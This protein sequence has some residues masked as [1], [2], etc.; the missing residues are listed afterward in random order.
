MSG[1]IN[2]DAGFRT[3]LQQH[4]EASERGDIEAEHKIYAANAIL[5]YPQSG[6]RFSGRSTIQAQRGAHPGA[7]RS[8]SRFRSATGIVAAV[9]ESSST[10]DSQRV[11]ITRSNAP[12]AWLLCSATLMLLVIVVRWQLSRHPFPG[13]AWAAQVGASPKPWL[14]FAITRAYQQVGR[15]IVAIG[16]VLVMLAWLRRTSG[17]RAAQGLLIA[18]LASV[19][20]GLIKT[21]C[22]PTSLWLELHHVG[23]NFPSGVVTFVTAAGGYL[24]L[25][26]RQQGRRITP[27]V[28]IVIIVGAG[29]ARVLGGQHVVS[30]VLGGYMLGMAWLIPAY[31]YRVRPGYRAQEEAA[32]SIAGLQAPA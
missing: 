20:C 22:G 32:W 7:P 15:P 26:A 3:R 23:S 28:L 30:D 13:D 4:W 9:L 11:R 5:D 12:R 6:E 10:P 24:A 17:R 2:R 1:E 8:L 18:L 16:E 21:I 27:A 25:V 14:I 19:T 31:M 29:P